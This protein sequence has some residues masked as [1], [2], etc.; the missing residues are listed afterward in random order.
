VVDG[1]LNEVEEV[2]GDRGSPASVAG[3]LSCKLARADEE[4]TIARTIST[5]VDG[6]RWSAVVSVSR[7]DGGS[8]SE[9]SGERS[10]VGEKGAQGSL[11]R[12]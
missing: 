2:A 3:A 1:E 10:R 7:G 11:L 4:V 9:Q 8:Q 12:P 6:E 5:D